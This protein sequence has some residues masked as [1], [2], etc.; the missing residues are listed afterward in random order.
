[1][2]VPFLFPIHFCFGEAET[3]MNGKHFCH[4]CGA[5][6]QLSLRARRSSEW[7]MPKR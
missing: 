5:A 4:A 1:V 6:P 2:E 7:A 3:E